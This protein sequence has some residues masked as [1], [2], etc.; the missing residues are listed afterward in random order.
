VLERQSGG[1]SHVST[2]D[3]EIARVC[4]DEGAGEAAIGILVRDASVQQWRAAAPIKPPSTVAWEHCTD[5]GHRPSP[6]SARQR[7]HRRSN[8]LAP[9]VRSRLPRV[10]A[11]APGSD[12]EDDPE[13]DREHGGIA[14]RFRDPGSSWLGAWLIARDAPTDDVDMSSRRADL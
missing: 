1:E 2:I 11:G 9:G 5:L 12:G 4:V 13:S 14:R 7:P 6:S 10:I 3:H 8:A